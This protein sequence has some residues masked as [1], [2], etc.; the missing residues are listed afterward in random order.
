MRT[1]HGLENGD[2]DRIK[3]QQNFMRATMGELLSGSTKNPSR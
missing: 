1:R 2:F 3:R